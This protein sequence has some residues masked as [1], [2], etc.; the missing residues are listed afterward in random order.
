MATYKSADGATFTDEDLERWGNE[1]ENG[2]PYDGKHLGLPVSGRPISV[3]VGA[4]PF[5][6]R[7]D[8]SR[9]AQLGDGS[10]E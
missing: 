9:R 2:V 3:G 1:A 6:P 4:K 7:L 8:R 10:S 5:T